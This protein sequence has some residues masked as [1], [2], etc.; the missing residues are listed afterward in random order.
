VIKALAPTFGGINLEDIKAPECFYIEEELKRQLSIPL[1]HDDQ[2]GTAIIVGAALQNALGLVDKDIRSIQLVINGAGAGAIACA[3]LLISLGVQP[4][5]I[6][7]CDTKGVIR[8]DRETLDP[9]K[10]PFATDRPLHTLTDAIRD[11]DV[12]LGLSKADILQPE[13]IRSMSEQAIIFALANP[14]P[15][16]SYEA[17]MAAR[18]D[19]IMATGRSDYPN[20]INNVLGFPYIFRGALDVRATTIN[21]PMKLA[22]VKALAA[23]AQEPVPDVVKKA[24]GI[25]DLAFGRAYLLPKP[26]DPRLITKVSMAVAKAAMES[27]VAQKPIQDWQTYET[28]LEEY[29]VQG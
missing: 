12:F 7:M 22:A 18:Q 3:K 8:K 11:A 26:L 15:E 10:A 19:I 24:Y 13:H 9:S 16:I 4:A 14:N 5:H 23:L 21:E 20:Q 2:H 1:M 28:T 27:G 6:V 25:S 29:L 17:A